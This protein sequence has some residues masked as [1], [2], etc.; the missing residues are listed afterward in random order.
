MFLSDTSS[1]NPWYGT[2]ARVKNIP[3]DLREVAVGRLEMQIAQKVYYSMYAGL[4]TRDFAATWLR[5]S[6]PDTTR[7]TKQFVDEEVSF[8]TGLDSLNR[9][10]IIFDADHDHDFRREKRIVLTAPDSVTPAGEKVD[11]LGYLEPQRVSFDYWDGEHIRHATT[12]IAIRRPS[13]MPKATSQWSHG[14]FVLGAATYEHREGHF[15]IGTRDFDCYMSNRFLDGVYTDRRPEIVFA[16]AGELRNRLRLKKESLGPGDPVTLDNVRYEIV[17]ISVDGTELTL[18]RL[19][20]AGKSEG[21]VVGSLANGFARRSVQGDSVHLKAYRG[22]YVL[23]DFWGSWCTGC[24]FEIPYLKDVHSVLS[25][26]GLQ[27]IG[28]AFDDSK[29]LEKFMKENDVIWPQILTTGPDDPVLKSYAI[30]SFPTFYLIDTAGRIVSHDI[31]RGE[32]LSRELFKYVGGERE[33]RE[34]VLR[35]NVEFSYKDENAHRVEVAGDF[36]NWKPI[37]LYTYEGKFRRRITLRPGTYQYKF[38]VDNA[39]TLDPGNSSTVRTP[40]NYEN[41]VLMV[42]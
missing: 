18:R 16:E 7:L 26:R 15:R 5:M 36:S 9:R 35:G 41:N 32:N 19:R 13:L 12:K 38:L 29:Y 11:T 23:L 3:G 21:R 6:H 14:A 25:G 30:Q 27:I 28:I 39:L 20:H 37:A 4:I 42:E 31:P 10:V 24:V 17:S 34:Y 33:F 2:W 22:K 1:S 40:E 8:I